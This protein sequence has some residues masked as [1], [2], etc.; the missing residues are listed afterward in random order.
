MSQSGLPL[1]YW[2]EAIKTSAYL[3]NR[4]PS[5]KIGRKTPFFL[6]QGSDP[7][8]DHLRVF[9]CLCFATNNENKTKFENRATKGVLLGYFHQR[10]G[11]E[12][13]DIDKGTLFTNRDVTF[14]ENNFPFLEHTQGQ[15]M[16]NLVDN[17]N[18]GPIDTISN[19]IE[20][21][22]HEAH[23]EQITHTFTYWDN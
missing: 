6:L 2:G 14:V 8:Y 21:L 22:E 11:Y 13:L 3:I 9:G 7:Q 18:H 17:S 19:D 10:K 23:T 15:R 1:K 20:G 5:K 4:M 16:D 12:I